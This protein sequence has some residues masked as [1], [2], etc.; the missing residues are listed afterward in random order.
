MKKRII[1]LLIVSVM[2]PTF[3]ACND[4]LDRLWENP[5]QYTP[6]PE[7]VCSGLFTRIQK[8]R[9]W[10]MDYGEWY[11]MFGNG[12]IPVITQVI[13]GMMPYALFNEDAEDLLEVYEGALLGNYVTP[14]YPNPTRFPGYSTN[15]EERKRFEYFYTE[16][17]SYAMIRDEVVVLEGAEKANNQIYLELATVLKNVVALQTV[18]LFNKIP[19]STALRG[20][21]GVFFNLYDDPKTIYESALDDYVR[22][23][24]DLPAVASAMSEKAM[25]VFKK[26]DIFFKGDINKWVKYINSQILRSTVRASGGG[27]NVSNYLT[28]DVLNNQPDGDYTFAARQTNDLK[29][30]SGSGAGELFWRGLSDRYWR[31]T[32]PDL[33]IERMKIDKTTRVYNPE[34]DDPRLPVIALGFTRTGDVDDPQPEYYGVSGNWNRNMQAVFNGTPTADLFG[35]PLAGIEPG[36]RLNAKDQD[37]TQ[38]II[39]D[40]INWLDA[41]GPDTYVKSSA[42]SMYNPMTFM[43]V[44][45][46]HFK[47]ESKAESELFLAEV[48]LKGLASAG[49]AK[50]HL[51]N[52]VNASIDFWYTMN[53]HATGTLAS[54]NFEYTPLAK[55]IL[56]PEKPA[57]SAAYAAYIANTLNGDVEHDMEIIMQQKYIHLNLFGIYELFAE[58]RRT[59]HPKLEPISL[60]WAKTGVNMNNASLMIE[61]VKYPE[62][63][64][65]NNAEEYRKVE[66]EDNWTTPIFWSNKSSESYFLPKAIKD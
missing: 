21:E 16:F 12:G 60:Y 8:N 32:I 6:A 27:I 37:F 31:I 49:T 56:Q 63:E 4:E 25:N 30:G 57:N 58:L 29:W 66:S 26:Q 19:Y 14:G 50:Q 47:I 10:Q 64:R 3:F 39:L 33:I 40:D 53:K 20:N 52:A 5:N 13:G 48:A 18:D 42:W 44:D 41:G 38:D 11:W 1:S 54:A 22:I 34:V 46:Y 55:K 35:A 43:C 51:E 9:F 28:S 62:S 59:R 61:R 65:V 15:S 17:N 7:D 24:K 36:R 2:L 23:A 45:N